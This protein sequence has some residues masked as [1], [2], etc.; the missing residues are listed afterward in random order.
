MGLL[1]L[2][3]GHFSRRSWRDDVPGLLR[4]ITDGSTQSDSLSRPS[5]SL[6][7]APAGVVGARADLLGPLTHLSSLV[8]Q[9]AH[10]LL[11]PLRSHG[12]GVS[13]KMAL[14]TQ[15]YQP[16]DGTTHNGPSYS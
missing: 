1:L 9:P 11:P 7:S 3:G 5:T 13:R 14:R 10:S 15:Y 6:T 2:K 12:A 4:L 8:L 16:R